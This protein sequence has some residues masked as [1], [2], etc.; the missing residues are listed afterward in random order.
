[1]S[2]YVETFRGVIYPWHCDHQGHMSAMHYLG[3]FDQAFWHLYSIM[4]F[5]RA[6]M[7][8][9]NKGFATVKDIIEYRAEQGVGAAI[10]IESGLLKVG[11]S[12]A[13][14]FSVMKNSETNEVAATWENI[15]VYFD[16][17]QRTKTAI[18]D[19]ER[20]RMQNHLVEAL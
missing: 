14:S 13:V 4:G 1:M 5:T 17:V 16:L 19:P 12:S 3:L 18:S 2:N 8:D 15:A 10:V 9:N 20:A 11:N 6:Y 7:D